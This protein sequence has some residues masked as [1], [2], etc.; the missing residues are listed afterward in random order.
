M[1]SKL[2]SHLSDPVPSTL[3][4]IRRFSNDRWTLNFV[5]FFS[6]FTEVTPEFSY[7]VNVAGYIHGSPAFNLQLNYC[8][9]LLVMKYTLLQFALLEFYLEFSCCPEVRLAHNFLVFYRSLL[10][11]TLEFTSVIK[12]IEL[13]FFLVFPYIPCKIEF[14]LKLHGPVLTSVCVC[15]LTIDLLSLI[16]LF[17]VFISLK[18][19]FNSFWQTFFPL[20]GNSSSNLS[21]CRNYFKL[22]HEAIC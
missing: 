20:L 19:F 13:S 22:F 7:Y 4:L 3:P 8:V 1:H 11:F 16:G 18:I 6:C 5:E 21:F 9:L 2:L 14:P 17:G 10:A 12:W 15:R